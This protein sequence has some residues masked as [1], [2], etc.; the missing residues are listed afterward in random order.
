MLPEGRGCPGGLLIGSFQPT[1]RSVSGRFTQYAKVATAGTF[2]SCRRFDDRVRRA[3]RLRCGGL[4]RERRGFAHGICQC[5]E[6]V[7]PGLVG[8]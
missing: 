4:R 5:Q 2:R 6:V 8:S 3:L 1:A 7:R